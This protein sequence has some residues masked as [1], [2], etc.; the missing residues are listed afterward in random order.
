MRRLLLLTMATLVLFAAPAAAGDYA[1]PS[2]SAEARG[3][4]VWHVSGT[5]CQANEAVTISVSPGDSTASTLSDADGSFGVD[6]FVGRK[7]G[8][9]T[10]TAVCGE[11]RQQ[12]T[13]EVSGA[14]NGGGKPPKD[15]GAAPASSDS[16]TGTASDATT[17]ALR[18][19]ALLV[20]AGGIA[21]YGL[22]KRRQRLLS[23]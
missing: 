7:P 17:P 8:S 18:A 1:E 11:L 20:M 14:D 5:G 21:G 22:T 2:I 9:Y 13:V 10:I 12:I 15:G 3:N 16:G 23:A 4:G 19:G 6:T